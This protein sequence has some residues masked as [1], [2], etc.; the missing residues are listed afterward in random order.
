MEAGCDLIEYPDGW[1][2]IYC[3]FKCEDSFKSASS[4][5]KAALIFMETTKAEKRSNSLRAMRERI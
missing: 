1:R 4:C 2:Y 3:G 5:A